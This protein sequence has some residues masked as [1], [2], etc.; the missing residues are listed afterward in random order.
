[1]ISIILTTIVCC[2]PPSINTTPLL[3]AMYQV[4]S[5]GGKNLVGDFGQAIGPYQIHWVY[6]KDATVYDPTIKGKY[7]D[8]KNKE[9]S[10]RIIKAYWARYAPRNATVEQLAR[11]HNGGGGILAKQFGG[12]KKTMNAWK[13]TT[14]YWNKIKQEMKIGLYPDLQF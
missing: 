8:C 3:D 1:M 6:W 14:A 10:E 4:E 7:E 11:I 13:N 2:T 12:S 9:Y 5:S